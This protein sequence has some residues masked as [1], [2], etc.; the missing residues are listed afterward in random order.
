[1]GGIYWIASYPK[2]GNT[3]FRTFL[4]N[5]LEDDDQP[6]DINDI[7]TGGIAS[8]RAWLDEVLGIDTADLS[9]EE[10]ERLRPKVYNWFLTGGEIAYRKIHDAYTYTVDNEPLVGVEGTIGAIYIIRNPLDVAVSY[11]FHNNS[12]IDDAI[13]KMGDI[14]HTL[15]RSH[16]KFTLQTSQKML[17]WSNH[18]TSWV[19]ASPLKCHV[20]RYEDMLARPLETFAGAVCFLKLSDDSGRLG[21]SIR[22]SEFDVLRTNENKTIFRMK[23]AHMRNFFRNGKSGDWMDK[24]TSRQV[25]RIISDHG[26]V[27]R[28]FGYLNETW[29]PL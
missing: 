15:N 29:Q 10:A 19:D 18:V 23:P 8:S 12:S 1:M 6:V 13:Q 22:F 20:I 14:N 2:S 28:R 11:A 4:K 21:K 26:L 3:W 7:S 9:E 17:T 27:M 24:L 5:Y 16:N 25:E